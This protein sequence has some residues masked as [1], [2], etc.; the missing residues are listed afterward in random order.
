MD[1]QIVFQLLSLFLVVAAGPLVIFLLAF[2]N[3]KL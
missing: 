2:S 3:S 1:S